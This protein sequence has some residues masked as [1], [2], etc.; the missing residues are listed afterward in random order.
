M[1]NID[2]DGPSVTTNLTVPIDFVVSI[3]KV[4]ARNVSSVVIAESKD[5]KL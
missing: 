2:K 4:N 1:L 5:K 3:K